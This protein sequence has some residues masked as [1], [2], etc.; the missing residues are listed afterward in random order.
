MFH[1]Y[2]EHLFM[3]LLIIIVTFVW[4]SGVLLSLFSFI[5]PIYIALSR[6]SFLF[7]NNLLKHHQKKFATT[8]WQIADWW[9]A[10]PHQCL[11]QLLL[12][13]P[14]PI[15]YFF[16]NC[17]FF[18]FRFLS[19]ILDYGGTTAFSVIPSMI[20]TTCNVALR[21]TSTK[22]SLEWQVQQLWLVQFLP[23]L[24]LSFRITRKLLL[25]DSHFPFIVILTIIHLNFTVTL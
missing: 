23:R 6:C 3:L 9:S 10:T 18:V 12:L 2:G 19:F 22:V 8:W 25:N 1:L 7:V 17:S 13:C 16:L 24:L 4:K 21:Q 11:Y 14:S 20:A 15:R 5:Y